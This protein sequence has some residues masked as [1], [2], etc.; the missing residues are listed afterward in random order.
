M[1]QSAPE[2]SR[3]IQQTG[4]GKTEH[5]DIAFRTGTQATRTSQEPFR[6]A[7]R[8]LLRRLGGTPSLAYRRAERRGSLTVI[9]CS[10]LARR[11]S[12]R[13][14]AIGGLIPD[15][16]DLHF[17]ILREGSSTTSHFEVR[18]PK[19]YYGPSYRKTEDHIKG[20]CHHSFHALHQ[21]TASG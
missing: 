15:F 3:L 17:I 7:L 12:T 13:E 14:W 9:V 2:N 1:P 11:A 19:A 18:R 6:R 10:V 21:R 5:P 8:C 4:I 16:A 20:D